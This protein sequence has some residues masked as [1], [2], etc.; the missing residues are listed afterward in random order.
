MASLDV[1]VQIDGGATDSGSGQRQH[2]SA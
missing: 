2:Q 1:D